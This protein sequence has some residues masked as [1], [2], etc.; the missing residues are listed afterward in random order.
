M[1]KHTQ[2]DTNPFA[3]HACSEANEDGDGNGGALSCDEALK[4]VLVFCNAHLALRHENHLAIYSAGLEEKWV[5]NYNDYLVYLLIPLSVAVIC[6]TL[7]STPSKVHEHYMALYTF[8]QL[9]TKMTPHMM[10][11]RIKGSDLSMMQ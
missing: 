11:I 5:P 9:A 4:S 2:L 3:W 8:H 1:N 7:P 10:R 6:Y